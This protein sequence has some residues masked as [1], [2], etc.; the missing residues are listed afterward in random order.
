MLQQRMLRVQWRDR[1]IFSFVN[2]ILGSSFLF[3]RGFFCVQWGENVLMFKSEIRLYFTYEYKKARPN[4]TG[5]IK[6][7]WRKN[8]LFCKNVKVDLKLFFFVN[9]QFYF[10]EWTQKVY[11]SIRDFVTHENIDFC[12]HSVNYNSIINKKE[13][14]SSNYVSI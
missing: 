2:L 7:F 5:L 1:S 10:T 9:Y 12:V 4:G 11:I 8:W 14:L 3:E 13:Q 6:K